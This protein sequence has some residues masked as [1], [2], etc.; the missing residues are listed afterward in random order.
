MIEFSPPGHQQV[1][2]LE[3]SPDR[4]LLASAGYQHIRMY[5]I[6]GS[7]NPNPTANYE[8]VNKNVTA[9]GF[10]AEGRF[11]YSGSEDGAVRIWDLRARNQ[12]CRILQTGSPVN[13]VSLHC[14]QIEMFIG[15]QNGMLQI[16]DLRK[17]A[18]EG[19]LTDSDISI[20]H[21]S[22]EH[23]GHYLAAVDNK[24]S[25]YMMA[26]K[27]ASGGKHG[28]L[29]R[30]LKFTAHKR[31]ALKCRFSPDST[32]LVTTSADRTA[33]I[34]RS[35]DLLPL[36]EYDDKNDT[37]SWPSSDNLSPLVTLKDNVQRWVW[38]VAFSNDS[39]YCITGKF[40]LTSSEQC[41]VCV[42]VCVLR[43]LTN[44]CTVVDRVT[45]HD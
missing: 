34:W 45:K 41:I 28:A 25:C 6:I 16:W 19:I 8:G 13:C 37:L 23:E 36:I 43:D 38:D 29:Q 2:A 32:L 44:S 3:I 10:Q 17:D 24:G 21:L 35:A 26:L 12:H 30:R 31:Y 22:I 14:N 18:A 9:V 4:T 20:Q 42:C 7:S 27:S 15:N 40:Y 5:D 1:N 39:Q 11:M 33:K